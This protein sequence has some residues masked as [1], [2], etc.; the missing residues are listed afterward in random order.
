MNK[1]SQRQLTLGFSLV[2]NGTHKVGWRHPNAQRDI[3]MDFQAWVKLAQAAE[4][5]AIHFLF[6]ADGQAVR[7]RARNVNELSY[8]GRIDQ[9][10]PL[11]LIAALSA[12]TERIG[13]IAT[14]ST[15]YNEPYTIAR[16]YAS[17]DH[18]SGGRVGWNVVTSWSEEEAKNFNRQTNLEHSV[19]Y[20]RAREFVEVVRGLWDSWDD[21]AFIRDQR[22]GRYFWPEK[23]HVL[24]HSGEHFSVRGP[25]NISRSPQGHPVIAQA[26][27]SEP[28]QELA[29]WSADLVYTSQKGTSEARRFYQDVKGRL[30]KFNREPNSM[31]VMPGML[32]IIGKSKSEAEDKRDELTALLNPAVDMQSLEDIFGD[33]TGY[34]LD[35][36]APPVPAHTNAV[37]SHRDQW[38]AR[39]KKKPMTL[40]QIYN[41]ISTVTD[42]HLVVGTAKDIADELEEW[43]TSEAC[44]GFN[45]MVP[46]MPGPFHEFLTEVVPELRRRGLFRK[47][48]TGNTLRE[49]LGL[50][51]PALASANSGS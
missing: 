16:K 34:D 4:K 6:W 49:N 48:Y 21:D 2:S 33:L 28:G 23:M 8:Q 51:R 31:I 40:R 35:S 45:V 50:M 38:E 24:N 47:N 41:E 44:D 17:L 32:P 18:I 25:L 14:A 10:E 11:T 37:K 22:S 1:S 9:F 13:F 26:G 15:T 39:L 20:R 43:F 27:G 36:V 12:L 19:R 3:S 5:E 42:H 30:S 7:T 29:A 46:Y